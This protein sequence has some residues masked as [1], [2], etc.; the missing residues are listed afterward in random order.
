MHVHVHCGPIVPPTDDNWDPIEDSLPTYMRDVATTTTDQVL[1]TPDISSSSGTS[2][3]NIACPSSPSILSTAT[4]SVALA[5]VHSTGTHTPSSHSHSSQTCDISPISSSSNVWLAKTSPSLQ[6]HLRS[7]ETHTQTL[8]P[9]PY[10]SHNGHVSPRSAYPN[11]RLSQTSPSISSHIQLPQTL[12]H[13]NPTSPSVDKQL[14]E[15]MG[16]LLRYLVPQLSH[17]A[18]QELSNVFLE[19]TTRVTPVTKR[20]QPHMVREDHPS[21]TT[22]QLYNHMPPKRSHNTDSNAATR[23]LHG[24]SMH[25]VSGRC[26][27]RRAKNCENQRCQKH[28]LQL[29]YPC[30]KHNVLRRNR[31]SKKRRNR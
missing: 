1:P 20:L 28:C 21:T 6:S 29:G 3:S 26:G 23:A 16:P 11:I 31:R 27:H 9:G 14:Q 2:H 10:R 12:V 8:T 24:M 18:R 17:A 5:H 7:S 30:F 25:C 13:H 4:S 22:T 15:A 19:P